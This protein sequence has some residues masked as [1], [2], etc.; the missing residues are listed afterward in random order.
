MT[1]LPELVLLELLEDIVFPAEG[2]GA[3]VPVALLVVLAVLDV[4]GVLFAAMSR[5]DSEYRSLFVKV[6]VER[7]RECT[8]G[9]EAEEEAEVPAGLLPKKLFEEEV[10]GRDD[11][12]NVFELTS[13]E[14]EIAGELLGDLL[15]QLDIERLGEEFNEVG[16]AG[17]IEWASVL[18]LLPLPLL[19][20][21]CHLA[22][23][24]LLPVVVSAVETPVL[25]AEGRRGWAEAA[26]VRGAA[27]EKKEEG[28]LPCLFMSASLNPIVLP[29]ALLLLLAFDE[30]FVVVIVVFEWT[31]FS[32]ELSP[33]TV[34]ADLREDDEVE[35]S[36]KADDEDEDALVDGMLKLKGST[37]LLLLCACALAFMSPSCPS[38]VADDDG[39]WK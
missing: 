25:L 32:A 29:L 1:V 21:F 22:L 4:L 34:V 3:P 36:L 28:E 35:G 14:V 31:A 10:R 30:A 24:L 37:S 38:E 9:D 2:R 33:V 27:A 11:D 16:L 12:G 20:S 13:V 18:L 23:L 19:Y 26:G 5:G 6:V 17:E 39:T 8:A 15:N 7:W